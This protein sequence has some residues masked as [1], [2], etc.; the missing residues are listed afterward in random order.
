M[1]PVLADRQFFDD[2]G[3]GLTVSGGEPLMQAD[4][5]V[6]LLAAGRSAGIHS[7]VETAGAGR[8]EDAARIAR[9]ADL[10]LYDIKAAPDDYHRLTGAGYD[11]T[12][13]NLRLVGQAG[14]E[15]WLRLPLVPGVNDTEFHFANIARL[16]ADVHPGRTE[17]VPYH[18][19]GVEKRRRFGLPD[20]ALPAQPDADRGQVAQ[21]VACLHR[22]G[23]EAQVAHEA[24]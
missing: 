13:A 10:V 2:T 21:W 17:I 20:V 6:A 23:V 8:P 14:C 7:A 12:A 24:L 16:V 1:Q 5:T 19:L 18:G 22:L 15:L 9:H 4:F 3:G 11:M